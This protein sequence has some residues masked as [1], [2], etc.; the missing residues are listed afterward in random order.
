MNK[1]EESIWDLNLPE[2]GDSGTSPESPSYEAQMAHA[3]FLLTTK[4]DSF[5]EER[6]RLMNPQVF[7]WIE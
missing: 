3:R 1:H 6:I 2:I 5:F 7:Q 4:D